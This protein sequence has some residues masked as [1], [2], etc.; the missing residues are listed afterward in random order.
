[1]G[2]SSGGACAFTMAWFHP[3]WYRR[4]LSYSGSFTKLQSNSEAPRGAWDYHENLIAKAEK[5]P[6]RVW[7]HVAEN[8]IGAKTDASSL[9]NWIVANDRMAEVLKNKGYHYRYTLSLNS[10]HVD[11]KVTNQ[12][13][14]EA[15][16]WLWQDYVAE[17]K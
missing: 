4:V 9:R 8:D 16:A 11:G 15:L 2:G 7:L 10:G 12:T 1:M 13:L 17:K 14:P 6:I 5:K 3:E